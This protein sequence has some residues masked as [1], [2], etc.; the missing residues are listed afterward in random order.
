MTPP[1]LATA[2]VRLRPLSFSADVPHLFNILLEPSNQFRY[3][4]I[5]PG[6]SPAVFERMLREEPLAQFVATT[7][8]NEVL[9]LVQCLVPDFQH[10]TAQLAAVFT[11]AVHGA[12]WPL[13]GVV[14]FVNYLFVA[15]P[16]R[17]IYVEVPEF[18]YRLMSRGMQ[19]LFKYEGVLTDHEWSLGQYWDVHFLSLPREHFYA[20]PVVER[21]LRR[22]DQTE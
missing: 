4:N 8:K 9:G 18:N 16:L 12:G 21:L 5:G 11:S 7:P 2:R 10:G 14:L 19:R 17:K 22:V 15:H 3:R 20:L 6:A 1:P 13:E